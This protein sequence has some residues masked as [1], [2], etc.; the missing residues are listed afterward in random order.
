MSWWIMFHADK[1][2]NTTFLK[3]CTTLLKQI[4]CYWADKESLLLVGLSYASKGSCRKK[5]EAEKGYESGPVFLH[6]KAYYFPRSFY[7]S[8]FA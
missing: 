6:G 2:I 7:D 5:I 8:M 3:A 4:L 1:L